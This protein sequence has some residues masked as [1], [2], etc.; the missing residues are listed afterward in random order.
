MFRIACAAVVLIVTGLITPAFAADCK[1]AA[2]TPEMLACEKT[3]RDAAIGKIR[4]AYQNALL[5]LDEQGQTLLFETQNA[6][7]EFR[8]KEC[9]RVASLVSDGTMRSLAELSCVTSMT[10]ARAD[11]LNTNPL[12]G[13]VVEPM[14]DK[15][16]A[17]ASITD[18][19]NEILGIANAHLSSGSNEDYFS[20]ERLSQLYSADFAAQ[21]HKAVAGAAKAGRTSPFDY[22]VIIQAQD[23][24]P[25]E[26]LELTTFPKNG[27]T[28]IVMAKFQSKACWGDTEAHQ[29]FSEV[30]FQM[31]EQDGRFQIDDIFVVVQGGAYMAIKAELSAM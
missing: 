9:V 6:W 21:Y 2:T 11:V 27:Q 23:G 4:S 22:D 7:D 28:T 19:V 10:L 13:E 5:G 20:S 26:N 15:T 16:R 31:I 29:A 1:D 25:L 12:T 8:D 14:H 24:C 17:A 3:A 18:P 30:R